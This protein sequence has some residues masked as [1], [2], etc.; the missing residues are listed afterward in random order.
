MAACWTEGEAVGW[1]MH[2]ITA[3]CKAGRAATS[4]TTILPMTWKMMLSCR[5][6]SLIYRHVGFCVNIPLEKEGCVP[7][8]LCN[9]QSVQG[10]NQ[11]LLG[12][13][14][15]LHRSHRALGHTEN[16]ICYFDEIMT[17]QHLC[18][19]HTCAK[20]GW[21]SVG[22]IWDL[23]ENVFS[24]GCKLRCSTFM[25]LADVFIHCTQGLLSDEQ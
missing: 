17:M 5:V 22:Q 9:H 10:H 1:L 6:W 25:Y 16:T 15:W 7:G 21:V 11:P 23:S 2:W 3:E 13:H 20:H 14:W 8:H 19:K 4:A 12:S 18:T 24:H